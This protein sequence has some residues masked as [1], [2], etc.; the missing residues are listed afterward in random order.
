MAG[1]TGMGREATGERPH[2]VMSRWLLGTPGRG[3]FATAV[4]EYTRRAEATDQSEFSE[5]EGTA[6]AAPT[7]RDTSHPRRR[8]TSWP[9]AD[10]APSQRHWAPAVRW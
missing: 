7:D 1:H 9:L 5:D 10:A 4:A 2:E 8:S 3:S 6:D